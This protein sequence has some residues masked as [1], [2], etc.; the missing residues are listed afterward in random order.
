MQDYE[1]REWQRKE[2]R[3]TQKVDTQVQRLNVF[4]VCDLRVVMC[5]QKVH[6]VRQPTDRKDEYD[7]DHHFYDLCV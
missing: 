6:V 3:L 2:D 5:D 4:P 7:D 1:S